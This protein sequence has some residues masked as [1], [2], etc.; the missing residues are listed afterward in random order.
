MLKPLI[1]SDLDTKLMTI[2]IWHGPIRQNNVRFGLLHY[3]KSLGTIAS[4]KDG[5]TTHHFLDIVRDTLS[6]LDVIFNNQD[7]SSSHYF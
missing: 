2:H 3:L 5:R 1:L 6:H 7:Y 4:Q